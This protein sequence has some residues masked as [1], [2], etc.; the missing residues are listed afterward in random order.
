MNRIERGWTVLPFREE[1]G[2][3][4][5]VFLQAYLPSQELSHST[6]GLERAPGSR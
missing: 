4:V 5:L 1:E 6:K 2:A 3:N